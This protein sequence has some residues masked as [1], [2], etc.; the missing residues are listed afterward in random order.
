MEANTKIKISSEF[1]IEKIL[2]SGS[3]LFLLITFFADIQNSIWYLIVVVLFIPLLVMVSIRPG[4]YYDNDKLYFKKFNTNEIVVPLTN[5]ESIS[6]V[7]VRFGQGYLL[8]YINESKEI[9]SLLFYASSQDTISKF[10]SH[11]NKINPN[12]KYQTSPWTN[13]L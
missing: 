7:M 12:I 5:I 9:E 8:K 13:Y 3:I 6:N 11:A 1:I 4:V 2:I 10:I